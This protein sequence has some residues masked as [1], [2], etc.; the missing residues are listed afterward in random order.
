MIL[1]AFPL[2]STGFFFFS[3]LERLAEG[4]LDKTEVR[5]RSR[6]ADWRR[7]LCFLELAEGRL[8]KTEVRSR[9]MFDD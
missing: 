7:P 1:L 3:K 9:S 8:V 4:R 2:P 6:S 5:S